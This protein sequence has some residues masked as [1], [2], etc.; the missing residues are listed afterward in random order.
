ML[1]SSFLWLDTDEVKDAQ[2]R[3]VETAATSA[4]PTFVGYS[5]SA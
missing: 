2:H 5:R 4:K 1:V 3:A